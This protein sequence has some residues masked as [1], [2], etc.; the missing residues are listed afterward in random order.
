M[1]F[2]EELFLD[3]K[4]ASMR[5]FLKSAI[6]LQFFKQVNHCTASWRILPPAGQYRNYKTLEV[7]VNVGVGFKQ[8]TTSDAVPFLLNIISFL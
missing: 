3:H 8:L 1:C 6:H 5:Q 4:S 2:S 7:R